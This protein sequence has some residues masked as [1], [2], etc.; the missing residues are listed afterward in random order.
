MSRQ[1]GAEQQ[2]EEPG[3]ITHEDLGTLLAVDDRP[4]PR[5]QLREDLEAVY[6]AELDPDKEAEGILLR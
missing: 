6:A 1:S 5:K 4:A 3:E 2:I